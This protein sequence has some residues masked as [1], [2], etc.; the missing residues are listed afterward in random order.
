MKVVGDC[1]ELITKYVPLKELHLY[2][3]VSGKIQYVVTERVHLDPRQNEDVEK[4]LG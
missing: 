3:E 4:E 1:N 2:L